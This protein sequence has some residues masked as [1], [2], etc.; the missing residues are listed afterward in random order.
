MKTEILKIWDEINRVD[1]RSN[2]FGDK[3]IKII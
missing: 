3:A 2:V 1:R